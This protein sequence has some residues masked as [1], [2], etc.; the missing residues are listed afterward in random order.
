MYFFQRKID[1]NP[2]FLG[3]MPLG[4]RVRDFYQFQIK[5]KLFHLITWSSNKSTAPKS[6]APPRVPKKSRSP[7]S[8]NPT[9][10]KVDLARRSNISRTSSRKSSRRSSSSTRKSEFS[11]ESSR[12]FHSS[13]KI[14]QLKSPICSYFDLS[15]GEE[16]QVTNG[17]AACRFPQTHQMI[18]KRRKPN[19]FHVTNKNGSNQVRPHF[20]PH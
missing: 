7:A 16:D 19:T 15:K 2:K 5:N 11:R 1:P 6:T 18:R 8:K 13:E 10:P 12:D 20:K 4:P 14:G 17:E 3:K 9:S